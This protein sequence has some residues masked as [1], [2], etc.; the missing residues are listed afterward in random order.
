MGPRLRADTGQGPQGQSSARGAHCS[1]TAVVHVRAP[2]CDISSFLRAFYC[3]SPLGLQL[4]C[5]FIS[6]LTAGMVEES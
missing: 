4:E 1:S 5:G 6:F 2:L 3:P